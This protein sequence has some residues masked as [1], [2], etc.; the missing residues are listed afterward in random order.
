MSKQL[1]REEKVQYPH[2]AWRKTGKKRGNI[3]TV[4]LY[5]LISENFLESGKLSNL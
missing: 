5:Q 3:T 2:L 1:S 4:R